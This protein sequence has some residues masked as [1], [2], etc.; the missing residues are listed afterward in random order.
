[1]PHNVSI[2]PNLRRFVKQKS[3]ENKDKKLSSHEKN[4]TVLAKAARTCGQNSLAALEFDKG[5]GSQSLCLLEHFLIEK[6]TLRQ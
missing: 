3:S 6:D 1:L 4:R 2:R 5:G